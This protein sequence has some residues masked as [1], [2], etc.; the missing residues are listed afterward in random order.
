MRIVRSHC[1]FIHYIWWCSVLLSCMSCLVMVQM[2]TETCCTC[3]TLCMQCTIM[4]CLTVF[5]FFL[6]LS[7][8]TALSLV[9][10]ISMLLLVP[11]CRDEWLYASGW[12]IDTDVRRSSRG[13]IEDSV[14]AF[15]RRMR[16]L[17][18]IWSED[19]Y[20]PGWDGKLAPTDYR[21]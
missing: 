15:S 14:L 17:M 6:I 11:L 4:L 5:Y 20:C 7:L 12:W 19:S 21:L 2:W 8:V 3:N 10:C 9:V 16:K 18:K 13:L 1:S